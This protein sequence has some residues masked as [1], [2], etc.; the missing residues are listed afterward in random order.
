MDAQFKPSHFKKKDRFSTFFYFH[1]RA[2]CELFLQEVQPRRRTS[3]L[4]CSELPPLCRTCGVQVMGS[5]TGSWAEHSGASAGCCGHTRGFRG[6]FIQKLLTKKNKTKKN[7]ETLATVKT[8]VFPAA[9][10]THSCR[11]LLPRG[12]RVG[13]ACWATTE[14]PPAPTPSSRRSFSNTGLIPSSVTPQAELFTN[15]YHYYYH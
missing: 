15:Y 1:I 8:G 11:R 13:G 14:A 10:R 6:K 4:R 2:G 5:G 12:G 9:R 7:K 3:C